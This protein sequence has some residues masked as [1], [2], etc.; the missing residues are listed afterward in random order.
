[1]NKLLAD[2]LE[3]LKKSVK[4]TTQDEQSVEIKVLQ[5][6][7]QRLRKLLTKEIKNGEKNVMAMT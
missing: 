6:E 3:H 7:C 4:M 5:K 1:M 2:D